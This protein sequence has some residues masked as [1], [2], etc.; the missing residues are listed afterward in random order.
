M[1]PNII[2]DYTT[3]QISDYQRHAASV[4]SG[5][6]WQDLYRPKN[7]QLSLLHPSVLAAIDSWKYDPDACPCAAQCGLGIVGPTGIGKTRA[8]LVALERY[9]V[10]NPV[11]GKSGLEMPKVEFV[12]DY[13]FAEFA[14]SKFNYED[15]PLR[16]EAKEFLQFFLDADLLFLDDLGQ[17]K[18][19]ERVQTELYHLVEQRTNSFLPIL[20]TSNYDAKGLLGRFSDK[21]RGQA[22][23]RRLKEFTHIMTISG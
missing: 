9:V 18:Y 10:E 14:L 16:V 13:D 20:W 1:N 22:I 23:L 19:T 11:C 21:S 8:M 3:E 7:T 17:S 6:Y 12:N 2:T 15:K 4:S 5:I